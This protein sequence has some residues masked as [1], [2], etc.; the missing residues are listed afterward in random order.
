MRHFMRLFFFFFFSR[1]GFYTW[2]TFG[3]TRVYITE[4]VFSFQL[5]NRCLNI[6][7][8]LYINLSFAYVLFVRSLS[9]PKP[10]GLRPPIFS[11]A[12]SKL[13]VEPW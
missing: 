7:L 8:N 6:W 1:A 9:P 11:Q 3:S 10:A 13:D 5:K 4:N 2:I 12:Y